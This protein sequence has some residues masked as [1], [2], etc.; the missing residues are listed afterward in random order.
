MLHISE[1]SAN[2]PSSK[3]LSY[4]TSYRE[5]KEGKEQK[6]REDDQAS[7]LH[8]ISVEEVTVFDREAYM[9]LSSVLSRTMNM[10]RNY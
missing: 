6:K 2:Q 10:Y 3:H 5:I 9:K 1:T 8:Y 4:L 7:I